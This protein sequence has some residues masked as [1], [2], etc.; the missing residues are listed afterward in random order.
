MHA[1]GEWRIEQDERP[2]PASGG[3]PQQRPFDLLRALLAQDGQALRVSTALEWL[4]PESEHDAQR[5][6]FDAA[7]LRLR[8]LLGDDSLLRLEGR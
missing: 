7:L 5:K 2:L 4:R 8:R 3:R 6:A 1:S